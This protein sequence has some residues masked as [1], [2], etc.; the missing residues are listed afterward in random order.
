[1]DKKLPALPYYSSILG[2][3]VD[4]QCGLDHPPDGKE[5]EGLLRRGIV[6]LEVQFVV[7]RHLV[8]NGRGLGHHVN[9]VIAGHR[10]VVLVD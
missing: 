10:R 1:M 8:L 3:R 5:E 9:V 2:W 6:D 4:L 7:D